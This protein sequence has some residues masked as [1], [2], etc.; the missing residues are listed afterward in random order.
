MASAEQQRES[1]NTQLLVV[2]F[3]GSS[4]D[5]TERKTGEEKIREQE[6]EFRQILDLVPQLVS[7]YGPA[8]LKLPCAKVEDG[9]PGR[10]EP[11]RS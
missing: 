1:L 5:V 8:G 10:R 6:M 11:P 9:C 7:V 3:V 2:H 4:M